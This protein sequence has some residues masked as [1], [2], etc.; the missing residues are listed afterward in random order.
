MKKSIAGAVALMGLALLMT[1][2]CSKLPQEKLDA[3]NAAIEEAKSAGA[4]IYIPE[5]YFALQDS[6]KSAMATIEAEKS[7]FIK[8]FSDA[9]AKLQAI[10]LQAGEVKT[11]TETRKEELKNEIQSTLEQAIVL[12]EANR[13]LVLEAPR[14]K[15]GTSVLMSIG[16]EL[17]TIEEN[18]HEAQSMLEQ[19]EYLT[20]LNKAVGARDQAQELNRE[21]GEVINKYKANVKARK[22]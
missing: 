15:E 5:S 13:Q 19:G 4:E 22:G 6:M 21:L 9:E 1:T 17:N 14:G 20:T 11:R 16:N 12:I 18:V 2:G 10:E 7:K 3:A 8:D